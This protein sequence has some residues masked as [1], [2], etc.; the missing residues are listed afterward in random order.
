MPA[1]FQCSLVTPECAVLETEATYAEVP[2]HDGQ[3]GIM[4][5][6]APLIVK[7]GVGKLSLKAAEGEE[8]HFVIDGGF[9]EMID[10]K[11][12][13][14]T[15]QAVAIED[16][17]LDDAKA[18]LAEAQALQ[19]ATEELYTKRQHDMALAKALIEL[20]QKH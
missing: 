10:N 2:A 5:D 11:L 16:I 4:H 17:D 14:L 19:P 8:Q 18:A 15:D 6:R 7:L 1:P 20:S 13:V 12:S 3:V 9:A